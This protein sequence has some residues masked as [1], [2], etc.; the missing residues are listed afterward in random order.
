MKNYIK[1]R[2]IS[3]LLAIS[4]TVSLTACVPGTPV[5]ESSTADSHLDSSE[6][7]TENNGDETSTE[8][9]G[10]SVSETPED[11]TAAQT[12]E[13]STEDPGEMSTETAD[14]PTQTPT[15]T[16]TGA[17][18]EAPS[19]N[20]TQM[21]SETPTGVPT[22]APSENATQT[23]TETPTQAPSE[24]ATQAPTQAPTETP[25]EPPVVE[26]A[27]YRLD[28]GSPLATLPIYTYDTWS[29]Y[30]DMEN[31]AEML[32]FKA[33]DSQG[34]TQYLADLEDAG[35]T[36]YAENEIVGNLYSTWVNDKL[37]VTAMYMP[38]LGSVRI[39]AEPSMELP[40]LPADNVYTDKGIE[41]V[42]V[43]VGT[44]FD[45]ST[46]NGMCYVYRLCDGSFLIIDAGFNEKACA[47]ALYET[48]VKLAPDPDN[49]VIAAWFITHA[50]K[51][52]VGGFY[53]FS[54]SYADKVT[55]EQIIY[56]YPTEATF[57]VCGT[58]KTHITNTTKFAGYYDDPRVIEAHPGQ[59]FY[60]RDAEVEMLYTWDLFSS[61]TISYMNNSSLVFTVTLNDTKLMMLGDCGPLASP[62]VVSLYGSYLDSDFIQVAHHGS[63]GATV[64]LNTAINAEVILWPASVERYGIIYGNDNNSP[65]LNA[66][67]LYIG[68][69]QATVIPLPFDPDGVETWE[70]F[71]Q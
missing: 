22:E 39:L 3:L 14:A 7:M 53:A 16:P 61:E 26:A 51:D 42:V 35:F 62:I 41:N 6:A 30:W 54:K 49:I 48:L 56:N 55:L 65:F 10:G 64:P 13:V 52:H 71:G 45:G 4:L 17:P 29:D 37:N 46:N 18:T 5:S 33:S 2:L 21:P 28:E 8:E 20:A 58:S 38:E 34:Y 40:G 59:M 36:L 27:P 60:I 32:L 12:S 15:E 11:S 25:T 47:K 67:H 31:G 24:N 43:Q 66:E 19:E 70:L 9:S 1:H 57:D 44:N 68:G 23:P 69:T 63:K 50:H